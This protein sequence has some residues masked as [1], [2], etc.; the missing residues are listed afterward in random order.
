M[1]SGGESHAQLS[2]VQPPCTLPAGSAFTGFRF[3][4]APPATNTTP[5]PI[6][7]HD[8]VERVDWASSQAIRASDCFAP[9]GTIR[10]SPNP[11]LQSTDT[12]SVKRVLNGF[13]NS[14][15]TL[16]GNTIRT[17]PTMTPTRPIRMAN[18]RG[19]IRI[20]KCGGCLLDAMSFRSDAALASEWMTAVIAA[21]KSPWF[22]V[23]LNVTALAVAVALTIIAPP[24][25]L[26]QSIVYVSWLSQIA[27]I[28]G[29]LSGVAAALVY[30]DAKTGHML[31]EADWIKLQEMLEKRD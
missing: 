2:F 15:V 17:T 29:G 27:L 10:V 26:L 22:Q 12:A 5:A 4:T 28:Y 9:N 3:T 25:G 23:W 21:F 24:I 1:L 14:I 30:L 8:H 7:T 19:F 18:I 20:L 31:N 16:F 11:E 13:V 6:S